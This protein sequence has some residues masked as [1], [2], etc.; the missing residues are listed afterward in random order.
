MTLLQIAKNIWVLP[1][2]PRYTQPAVGI[3]VGPT[4]TVLVDAGNSPAHAYK[5][6]LA[7][8]QLQ[9]PPVRYVIFT[10]H[11]WDHVLG[12][13]LFKV[14][15]IAQTLCYELLEALAAEPW[16]AEFVAAQ[17][18]QNPLLKVRYSA[19]KQALGKWSEARFVLPTITF[20]HQMTLHLDGLSL[21]LMHVGGQ[22]A[23]DSIIVS[24]PE[25]KV[26]FLGDCYYP[27]PYHLRTPDSAPDVKMLAKLLDDQSEI[28]IAG[29][30]APAART[31]ILAFLAGNSA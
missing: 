9:A 29:H 6:M 1:Y 25:A 27:P 28:Y 30:D 17:I 31:E 2:H 19:M 18:R 4:Q 11:H 26:T 15:I 14:P 22:H 7:L 20:S 24:V 23:E 3:I 5:I 13:A 8:E 12:A 16:S 10:H 21:V